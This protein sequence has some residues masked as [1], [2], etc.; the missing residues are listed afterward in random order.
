M[1]TVCYD[2]K[3]CFQLQ[4]IENPKKLKQKDL[5]DTQGFF[6]SLLLFKP[7]AVPSLS[8]FLP[9]VIKRRAVI[10]LGNLC[11]HSLHA[12]HHSSLLGQEI[13]LPL[14]CGDGETSEN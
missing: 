11:E 7:Q 4:V 3:E 12:R 10:S 6:F 2:F 13:I 1:T 14:L 5:G 9:S 8:W